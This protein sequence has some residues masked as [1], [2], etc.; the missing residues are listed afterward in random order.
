LAKVDQKIIDL[1][2]EDGNYYRIFNRLGG[3]A[4]NGILDYSKF[5]EADWRFYIQFIQ[6]MSKSN[7]F[8]EIAIQ[9]EGDS[10]VW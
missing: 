10:G 4:K 9:R 8:V 2:K 5:E 7:P 1:V 6:S 3:D